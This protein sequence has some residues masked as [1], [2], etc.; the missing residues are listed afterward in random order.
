[1]IS[2]RTFL[3]GIALT[4]LS[5]GVLHRPFIARAAEPLVLWG[6][7]AAPSI[8]LA[9]AVASGLLRELGPDVSFRT[10]K[11]PDELRAGIS[12]GSYHA[13]V[14]PTY[15][16]SNFYNRGLGV[17]LLNVLTN[18]LLYIVA[19]AGTVSDMASLKG[20]K[21]AVPLRNDMPD[22]IFRRLLA[23]ANMAAS[24]IQ[25]EY[26]GSPSEAMQFLM[27]GRVDAAFLT[28][29]ASTAAI[30]RA[31]MMG[32]TLERAISAQEVW[33]SVTGTSIIPQAGLAV[34]NKFSADL[35][36][37]GLEALQASLGTALAQV[38]KDPA[39]AAA[40]AASTLELPA[41]VIERSIP[42]SNLVAARASTEMKE[43]FTLFEALAQED[44]RIIGGKVPDDGF[45]AL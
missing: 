26:T 2:R 43:L 14:V 37:K 22:F 3:S 6:P 12:S 25:I 32:K 35:G 10:W 21:I 4:G 29:P 19:P 11:S 41:P 1:M 27:A 5:A 44:P 7:P 34:S 33:K 16:A 13:T 8:I 20:K 36:E 9:Q 24:E 15:V 39:A 23:S 40:A 31:S 30:L 18:G 28:E 17:R 38:L 42:Y 45:F